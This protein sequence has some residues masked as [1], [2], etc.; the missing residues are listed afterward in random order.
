MSSTSNGLSKLY[1]NDIT[2]YPSELASQSKPE[3][4]SLIVGSVD[5]TGG[6]ISDSDGELRYEECI[7]DD[8]PSDIPVMDIE[9]TSVILRS[10]R[11][12]VHTSPGHNWDHELIIDPGANASLVCEGRLLNKLVPLCSKVKGID[13]TPLLGVKGQNSLRLKS[14]VYARIM[15]LSFTIGCG[16]T[17]FSSTVLLETRL[18]HTRLSRMGM[19]RAR[20]TS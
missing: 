16:M 2:S 20:T 7:S 14:G 19:L 9:S 12:N 17:T 10:L 13:D 4:Q 18:L 1:S 15:V 11:L 5:S 6:I 8:E 3:A